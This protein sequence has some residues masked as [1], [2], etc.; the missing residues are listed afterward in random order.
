MILG[1]GNLLII[2][3]IAEFNVDCLSNDKLCCC[4]FFLSMNKTNS[5]A[6]ILKSS[7]AEAKQCR[8]KVSCSCQ[9][10]LTFCVQ[11]QV[12]GIEKNIERQ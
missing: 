8:G 11:I 2:F 6:K 4:P 10:K 9:S 3:L 12:H 1:T 5:L 7:Y